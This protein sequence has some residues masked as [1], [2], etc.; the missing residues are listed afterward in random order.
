MKRGGPVLHY[1]LMRAG[2]EAVYVDPMELIRNQLSL[3]KTVTAPKKGDLVLYLFANMPTHLGY[4]TGNRVESKWSE[5]EPA[6]Y[7]HPLEDAPLLYDRIVYLRKP[8]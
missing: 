8:S 7:S 6:V 1:A 2:E 4:F 5:M 3:Y